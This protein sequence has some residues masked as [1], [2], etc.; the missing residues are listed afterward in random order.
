MAQVEQVVLRR[1][2]NDPPYA[3]L[4][5]HMIAA[6]TAAGLTQEALAKQIGKPQSFIAKLERG[7]RSIDVIEFVAIAR[8]IGLDIKEVLTAVAA[9]LK[10]A[11]G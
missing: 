10:G 4:R 9:D 11:S 2:P 7:E 6:R 8:V 5:A 1:D 3:T